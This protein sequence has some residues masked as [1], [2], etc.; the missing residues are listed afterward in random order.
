MNTPIRRLFLISV[1]MFAS[2]IAML[3]YRQVIEARTWLTTHK[4]L[5]RYLPR[6]ASSEA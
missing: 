2:L 3:G 4:T 5:A 6:C 1:I